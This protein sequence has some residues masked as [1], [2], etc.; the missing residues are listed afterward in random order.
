VKIH[1]KAIFVFLGLLMAVTATGLS[2]LPNR[3]QEISA[4]IGQQKRDE[5]EM[6]VA[7]FALPEPVDPQEPALRREI[8]TRFNKPGGKPIAELA[9]GTEELALNSHWWWGLPALPTRLSDAIVVGEVINAQ[10]YL[11]SDKSGVY[12]EFTIRINEVLKNESNL[13]VFLGNEVLAER[14]GGAV[15]FPS[16]RLQRYTISQQGTPIIGRRYV[17]FLK[18][19]GTGKDFFLLTGY[20]LKSGR[21]FPLDGYGDKKERVVS[22]FTAFEGMDETGF[23][24]AVSDAISNSSQDPF[25]KDKRKQ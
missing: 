6:P 11:S 14:S 4:A 13:T 16:G 8:G 19:N 24:K 23:L 18:C 22:S 5:G 12:S 9:S 1:N 10:A 15:R 25:E 7:D 17:I 20:E 3:N 2:A 21:V